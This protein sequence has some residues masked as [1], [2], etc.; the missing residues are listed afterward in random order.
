MGGAHHHP[1]PPPP[2]GDQ[3]T[4][5]GLAILEERY[6]RGEIDREEFMLKKLDLMG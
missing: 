6:V 2:E 5:M 4:G 1:P 3:R